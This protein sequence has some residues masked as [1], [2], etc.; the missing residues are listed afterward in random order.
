[1]QSI[2]IMELL[3]H[4]YIYMYVIKKKKSDFIYR[5]ESSRAL[6]LGKLPGQSCLGEK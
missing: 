3:L 1:M 4:E 5:V 2:E 6:T